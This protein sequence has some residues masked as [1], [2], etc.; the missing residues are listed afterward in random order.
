MG[1][2]IKMP[3]DRT[4]P[5]VVMSYAEA[6]ALIPVFRSFK[7]HEWKDVRESATRIV[8]ELAQVEDY[9]YKFLGGKQIFLSDKDYE[10]LQDVMDQ[11]RGKAKS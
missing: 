5:Y 10:F 9:D 1:R 11:L 6:Q 3:T 8:N 4:N 7:P 2:W